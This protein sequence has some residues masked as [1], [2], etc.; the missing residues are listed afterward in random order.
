MTL[1]EC[2]ECRARIRDYIEAHWTLAREMAETRLGSDPEYA[3]A[4]KRARRLRTEEDVVMAEEMFPSIKFQS[5]AGV[6]RAM[7]RML[8]HEVRTGHKPRCWLRQIPE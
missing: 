5:S 2:E 3:Q 6:G 4:W 1:P 8:A 7:R